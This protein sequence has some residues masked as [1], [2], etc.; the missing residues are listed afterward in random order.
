MTGKLLIEM[1]SAKH[2]ESFE[3]N[4][5]KRNISP[6]QQVICDNYIKK[7]NNNHNDMSKHRNKNKYITLE[8][9]IIQSDMALNGKIVF[10]VRSSLFSKI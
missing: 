3:L 4:S 2:C 5:F 1:V 7:Q 9:R 6:L 8:D 10:V